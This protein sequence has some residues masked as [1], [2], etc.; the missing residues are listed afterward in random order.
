MPIVCLP[1]ILSD[2]VKQAIKIGK[3][4]AEKLKNMTSAERRKLFNDVLGSEEAAQTINLQFEKKLLLKNQERGLYGWVKD[5]TGISKTQKEELL[6]K[7][8]KTYSDKQSRIYEPAENEKFLDELTSD[9]FSKKYKTDVSL[10]EAQQITK[11]TSQMRKL[12]EKMSNLEFK[13]VNEGIQYGATRVA[14]RNY[15]GKLK[16]EARTQHLIS[17]LKVK[18][19]GEKLRVSGEDL[20]ISANFIAENARAI[21]ASLDDSWWLR[22]GWKTIFNPRYTAKWVKNFIKSFDDIYKTLK[23]GTKAGEEIID[24]TTAEIY[25][26]PNSTKGLYDLGKRL[27]IGSEEAIPTSA[28]TKIPILGRLF[29]AAN[30]AYEAGAMRM[31]ADI[32]DISYNLAKNAG[33]DLTDKFRVGNINKYVNSITGRGELPISEGSQSFV[34]KVF[35]SVKKW[36]S[37]FDF[38]TMPFNPKTDPFVRKEAAIGL[39]SN[40]TGTAIL[41]KLA[42]ILYPGSVEWDWKSANAGKVK[43]GNTRFD[44]TGGMGSMMTMIIRQITG[45]SKSSITGITKEFGEGFLSSDRW[46]VFWDYSENKLSPMFSVIKTLATGE[47]FQGE[48]T[49]PKTVL[50]GLTVPIIAEN[51]QELAEDPN[52]ANTLIAMIADGLGM[53]TNTYTFKTN[54]DTSG[55]KELKFF[56][57]EIGAEEFKKAND[58][59]NLEINNFLIELAKDSDFQSLLDFEKLDL[60]AAVKKDRKQAIFDEYDYKYS[61]KTPYFT[62]GEELKTDNALDLIFAYSKAIGKDPIQAFKIMLGSETLERISNDAL[63]VERVTEREQDLYGSNTSMQIDH[64]IPLQFG[65][66]ND[67]DNLELIPLSQHAEYTQVGNY[68]GGHLRAGV[69]DKKTARLLMSDVREGLRTPEEILNMKF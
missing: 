9:M 11:L 12:K 13:N 69:I 10:A 67:R 56:K 22:Q 8:R 61:G 41:L 16:L 19:I 23:G 35:F 36:K 3:L 34:N 47:T 55:G 28:P 17:P 6:A 50:G 64:I 32:A 42:D 60:I 43:I 48:K 59:Y 38:L 68:L 46:D 63:I 26:R 54:W 29:S 65:G 2:K 37:D 49:S 62:P 18:G 31:R 58:K 53:S 5:I 45:A 57:S 44:V 4:N 33:V 7:I 21:K 25:S 15:V 30:T 27:D 1:K 14:L 24:G 40:I 39:L 51:Y 66:T 20:G 52:S